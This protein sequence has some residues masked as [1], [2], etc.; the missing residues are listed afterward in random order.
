[1]SVSR[2]G[3][4]GPGF[5]L[6][7]LRTRTEVLEDVIDRQRDAVTRARR[8]GATWAQIAEA[9]NM[10]SRQAAQHKFWRAGDEL[11]AGVGE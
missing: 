1:M 7:A 4:H 6:D 5:Q 11:G 2:E 9:T 10:N 3:A 8:A